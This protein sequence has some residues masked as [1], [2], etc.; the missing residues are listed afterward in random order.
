MDLKLK[1]EEAD[2]RDV[3]QLNEMEVGKKYPICNAPRINTRYGSSVLL[4]IEGFRDR[5]VSVFLPKNI[6][7]SLR[8]TT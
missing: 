3:I 2:I 1:F 4:T 7:R 8:T 5:T 6:L